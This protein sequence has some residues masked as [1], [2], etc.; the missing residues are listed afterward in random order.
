MLSCTFQV[1]A[2]DNRRAIKRAPHVSY[3]V[4]YERVYNGVPAQAYKLIAWL[5]LLVPGAGLLSQW[6]FRNWYET[7]HEHQS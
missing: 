4:Y 6:I 7:K 1:T 5:C 3:S 2:H